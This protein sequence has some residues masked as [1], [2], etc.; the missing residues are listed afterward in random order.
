MTPFSERCSTPSI[1]FTFDVQHY[2]VVE[3]VMIAIPDLS[4]EDF[5]GL[6][7]RQQANLI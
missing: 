5:F 6:A 7:K 2:L 4:P 1:P 3:Y